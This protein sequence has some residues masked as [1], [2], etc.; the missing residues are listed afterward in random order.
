[1]IKPLIPSL[2]FLVALCAC[3][4]Q[5]DVASSNTQAPAADTAQ[6][7]NSQPPAADTAKNSERNDASA[8]NQVP[9]QSEP[10]STG[11]TQEIAAA[12]PAEP[13]APKK[14]ATSGASNSAKGTRS[15]D[16]VRRWDR[17]EAMVDRCDSSDTREQC[18]ADARSVYRAANFKCDA[19]PSPKRESC[20][21]FGEQWRNAQADASKSTVTHDEDPATTPASPG[22]PRPAERNRDST[23]QSQDA[24][25]SRGQSSTSH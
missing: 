10:Q 19:L 5:D 4:K 17:F 21:Q 13:K 22:D 15:R 2:A 6:S 18:L 8:T 11:T 7:N 16:P 1:M 12:P 20:L 9:A 24:N 14:H 3:S 23:K 25:D